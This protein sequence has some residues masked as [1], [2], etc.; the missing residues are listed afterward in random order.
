MDDNIIV[1]LLFDR[2][3]VALEQISHKYEKMLFNISFHILGNTEDAEECINDTYLAVWNQIPPTQPKSFSAFVCRLVRN[4]SLTRYRYRV[5]EK[6]NYTST[7]S[8]E[9]VADYLSE[10]DFSDRNYE[11]AELTSFMEEWLNKLPPKNR[12]IFIR[13]YRY[14]D[15]IHSIATTQKLTN[16]AVYLRIDRMK[17]SLKNFL[18][19]KGVLV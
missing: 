7:V 14:M 19:Q 16:S 15:D 9:E 18:I 11:Q 3:E 2:S 5:A 6:R 13:R 12:Y 1:K 17:K 8:L 4:L 10:D